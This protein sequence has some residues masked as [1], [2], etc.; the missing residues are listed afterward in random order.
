MTGDCDEDS[1]RWLL[2]CACLPRPSPLLQ[3]RRLT[4]TGPGGAVLTGRASPRTPGFRPSGAPRK[5]SPGR[6]RSLAARIRRRSSGATASSSRPP[7]KAIRY[8]DTAREALPRRQGVQ[9]AGRDGRGPPAHAAGAEHRCGRR[10][11]SL[12]T[13]RL[14]RAHVRRPPQERL[15]T[16]RRRPVTD[17][18]HVYAYF[19]TEG[20]LRVRLRWQA[21]LE[22][23]A[24]QGAGTRRRRGHVAG[25]SRERD[26]R[27]GRRRQ[28]RAL[29]HRRHRQERRQGA[30]ARGAARRWR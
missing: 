21:G 7:S 9:A 27:A 25:A 18:T 2:R 13:D 30:V 1:K 15:G 23:Q 8:L 6:R 5:T 28:R 29:V 24:R 17:G 12:D 10:Q 19:G 26:H 3:P 11:D 20:L 16:R 14:R 22:D 4:A